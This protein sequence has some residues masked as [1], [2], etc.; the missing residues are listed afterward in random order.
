MTMTLSVTQALTEFDTDRDTHTGNVKKIDTHSDSMLTLALIVPDAD[1][2]RDTA[3]AIDT[4][5]NN[6]ISQLHLRW[7]LHLEVSIVC[8]LWLPGV[9]STDGVHDAW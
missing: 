3:K 1:T 4:A 8:S 9:C 6:Y 7:H 2:D 5:T